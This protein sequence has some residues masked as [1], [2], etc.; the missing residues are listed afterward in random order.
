M[1]KNKKL[2][3]LV[4]VCSFFIG[5]FCQT[6]HVQANVVNIS[7]VDLEYVRIITLKINKFTVEMQQEIKNHLSVYSVSSE[8]I[9]IMDDNLVEVI[10]KKDFTEQELMIFLQEEIQ[11][12]YELESVSLQEIETSFYN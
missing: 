5:I 11:V 10:V 6:T 8:P 1:L 3:M 4:L 12:A 9:G 7:N 2:L